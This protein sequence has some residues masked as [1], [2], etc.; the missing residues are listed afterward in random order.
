MFV[1]NQKYYVS[2]AGSIISTGFNFQPLARVY[3]Q[4]MSENKHPPYSAGEELANAITHG[5]GFF[6]GIAVLAIL[7]VFASL[8]KGPWEIVSVSV[9]GSTFILLYLGST[10]YHSARRPRTRRIM[11]IID[12]SAIYLL[13]AGTYTPFALV[14]LRGALGW[15]IFGAIWGAALIGIFFKAFYAGRFKWLSLGSYLFM[16]WFCAGAVKPLFRELN[17]VGFVLLAAGGLCYSVGAVFYAWKSLKWSHSI[18]HLFVL[19][20]SLCHFLSILY[21]IAL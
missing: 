21:G 20:G 12:H 4:R 6:M 19:A 17:T 18:W 13:I 5:I 1:N 16:G 14:P 10:L 15:S 3:I 2:I 9:Y 7:I 11:K 8:R